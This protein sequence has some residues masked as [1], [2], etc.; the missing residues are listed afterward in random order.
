MLRR[1]HFILPVISVTFLINE[2]PDIHNLEE[3]SLFWLMFTVHNW[4]AQGRNSSGRNGMGKGKSKRQ[5]K[6]LLRTY[7]PESRERQQEPDRETHPSGHAS[8]DLL[9]SPNPIVYQISHFDPMVQLLYKRPHL[10]CVRPCCTSWIKRNTCL[11]R[12]ISA[13]K[14]G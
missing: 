9:F 1:G 10:E 14:V 2:T 12:F 3:D 4:P 7:R 8:R 5:N 13:S 11:S 6:D